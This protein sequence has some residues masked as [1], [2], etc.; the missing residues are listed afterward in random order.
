MTKLTWSTRMRQEKQKFQAIALLLI[1]LNE[2]RENQFY[3]RVI[4]MMSISLN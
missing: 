3:D 2:T 1:A 4:I